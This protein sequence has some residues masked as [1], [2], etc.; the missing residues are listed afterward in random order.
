MD[1]RCV[2]SRATFVVERK[3]QIVQVGVEQLAY[4]RL[5]G[6]GVLGVVYKDRGDVWSSLL[7]IVY[8]GLETGIS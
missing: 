5:Y 2:F 7:T 3:T 1:H 8:L 4:L 6:V